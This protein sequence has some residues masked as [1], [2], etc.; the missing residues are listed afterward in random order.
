MAR[1]PAEI[2]ARFPL[3]VHK[4]LPRPHRRN[5][6]FVRCGADSKHRWSLYPL[7]AER[8]WDLM[9]ACYEPPEE[10]D[11]A[12]AD[13]I[14]TGGVSKWDAFAQ[15]RF[16]GIEH[17]LDSYEHVFLIDDDIVIDHPGDIDRLFAIAREHD[18][19]VCQPSLSPQ[20]HASW[21]ITRQQPG[22]VRYTDFVETMVPILSA[23]AVE[24]LREDLCAAV[25]GYGLDL[26]FRRALGPQRRMAVID[27]VAVTHS[28][29]TNHETSAFYRFMRA[30]GVD[31]HEEARWFED[32]YSARSV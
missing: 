13:C 16:G 28:R 22:E 1:V 6:L 23:E 10:C 20:S 26:V 3:V 5:L 7:P 21:D 18:L 9:L 11:Y 32:R 12:Q 30:I 14:V 27:A 15:A 2:A 25:S 17:G 31:V 24:V 19:A 4:E 29:A 8:E